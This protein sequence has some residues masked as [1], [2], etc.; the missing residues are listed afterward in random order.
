MQWHPT[1]RGERQVPLGG[2]RCGE[3]PVEESG[4]SVA[5]G[6]VVGCG[7]VVPDDQTGR[8]SAAFPPE[9]IGRRNEV[10]DGLVVG[11]RPLGDLV[12]GSVGVHPVRPRLCAADRLSGEEGEH[13]APLLVDAEWARRA[14]EILALQVGEQSMHRRC[15]G[16]SGAADGVAHSDR[17]ADVPAVETMSP[18]AVDSG[19]AC[20]RSQ[21]LSVWRGPLPRTAGDRTHQKPV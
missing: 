10:G 6:R 4:Q 14:G 12:E 17:A 8:P 19:T 13:L 9:G 18:H 11:A 3:V 21:R 1:K 2:D 16:T 15:P 7:V 20:H 5:P